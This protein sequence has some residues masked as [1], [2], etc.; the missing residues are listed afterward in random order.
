M[1][2]TKEH[3]DL[4]AQFERQYKGDR[5]DREKDQSSWRRGVI[6]EHGETNALFLAFRRGYAFGRAVERDSAGVGRRP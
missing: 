2:N 1:L 4:M 5:L 3:S 6:Y